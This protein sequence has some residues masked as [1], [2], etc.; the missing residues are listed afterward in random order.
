MLGLVLHAA[1][2][3]ISCVSC[4]VVSRTG[5]RYDWRRLSRS[6][7]AGAQTSHD[8]I[9]RA[10]ETNTA[11]QRR[12]QVFKSIADYVFLQMCTCILYAI[13]NAVFTNWCFL[14]KTITVILPQIVYMY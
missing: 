14:I 2:V 13:F 12:A 1:D 11:K 3:M 10:A 8:V 6:V 4:D 7:G 9:D 5:C